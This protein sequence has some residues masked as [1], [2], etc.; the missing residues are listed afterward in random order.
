MIQR[1]DGYAATILSGTVTRRDGEAT[2][3]FPGRLIRGEQADRQ[4][5]GAAPARA[6]AMT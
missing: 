6:A 3:C 2:G 5:L 4:P 1:A